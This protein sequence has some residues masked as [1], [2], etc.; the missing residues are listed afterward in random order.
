MPALKKRTLLQIFTSTP[1]SPYE[2]KKRSR[3][4][5]LENAEGTRLEMAWKN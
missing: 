2:Q 5:I 1:G 4:M 3:L